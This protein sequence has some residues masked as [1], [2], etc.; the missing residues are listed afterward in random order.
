MQAKRLL[1]KNAQLRTSR[2]TVRDCSIVCEDGVISS[3]TESNE[4]QS[5]SDSTIDCAGLTVVPGFIEMHVHGFGG[6]DS[7]E[8]T[9]EA[10]EAMAATYAR[11]GV[12]SMLPTLTVL[13]DDNL[14]L[15][16]HAVKEAMSKKE[17]ANILG[18]HLEGPFLNPK[19]KGGIFGGGLSSPSLEVLDKCLD[20]AGGALR[21]M[22][23][24]PELDGGDKI[25]ERLLAKGIVVSIGHSGASYEQA[26]HAIRN[27][28]RYVAHLFNG[29][30]SI[31]ARDPGLVGAALYNDECCVEI[32][33][34]G[35]HVAVANVL[36]TL[37]MKPSSMVCL[38]TDACKAA[39]TNMDGFD[40]PS[41]FRVEIRDGRTWGPEGKLVGSVLTLDAAIRNVLSWT[42][43][44]LNEVIAFVTENPAKQLGLYPRKGDVS[45]GSDADLTVLDSNHQ[46]AHTIVGGRVVYSRA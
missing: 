29:M 23:L 46:V 32:I 25:I 43:L 40:N 30:T 3:V 42:K 22:T 19:Y 13:G 6:R 28:C 21:I 31:T 11:Y 18:I 17:G 16:S 1:L 4:K 10:I 44:T 7:R 8:G 33:A 41:G 2:K 39:G 15:S 9:I 45:P 26:V 34:D 36:A 27:G 12:T 14:R 35:H 5:S 38:V 37:K 24:A 20:F